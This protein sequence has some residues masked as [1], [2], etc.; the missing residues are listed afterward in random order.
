MSGFGKSPPLNKPY[1]VSDY[2]SEVI[3][4]LNGLNVNSYNLIA[5]SFGARVAVKMLLNDER[6]KKVILTGAAGIKPRRKPSYYIKVYAY[7]LLKKFIPENKLKGFGSSEYK[8]LSVVMKKSYLKIVN[9]HLNYEYS[10]IK[11][12]TLIIF[13]ENDRETPPYMAKI[14]NK[15]IKNSKLVFIKNAGHFAFIDRSNEFNVCTLEFLKG[16]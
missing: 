8:T 7:K 2:A 14:I 1:S 12:Q 9:E 11:N 10:L 6:I 4:F 5:H 13:G 16:G 15:S 3:E